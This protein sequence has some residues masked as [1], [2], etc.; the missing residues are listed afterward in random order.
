VTQSGLSYVFIL[1]ARESMAYCN[2]FALA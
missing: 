1:K 2:H